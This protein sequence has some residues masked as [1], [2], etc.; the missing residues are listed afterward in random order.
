MSAITGVG[1]SALKMR[2][3]RA[4]ARLRDLLEGEDHGD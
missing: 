2:V 3:S 1:V 4:C